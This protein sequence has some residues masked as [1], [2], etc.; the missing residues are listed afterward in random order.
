MRYDREKSD[1]F[2]WS[3]MICYEVVWQG[4]PRILNAEVSIVEEAVESLSIFPKY[5]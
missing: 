1:F 2:E 3:S 5:A 4:V